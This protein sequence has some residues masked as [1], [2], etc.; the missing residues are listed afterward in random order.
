M[1]V[2][3]NRPILLDFTSV[4]RV[5]HDI[6][7]PFP[8]RKIIVKF[9]GMAVSATENPGI[10]YSN[11]IDDGSSCLTAIVQSTTNDSP[12]FAVTEFAF[13]EPKNVMGTYDF[14]IKS[15]ADVPLI[16]GSISCL[17]LEFHS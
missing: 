11:L 14:S 12:K 16:C 10:L 7:I 15:F 2:I 3:C 17:L 4:S 8:V 6:H 5:T 13:V 1:T 9:Y